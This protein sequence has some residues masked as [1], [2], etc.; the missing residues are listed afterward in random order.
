MTATDGTYM[1]I[2][3]SLAACLLVKIVLCLSCAY[4]LSVEI[5]EGGG[6]GALTYISSTGRHMCPCKD[7]HFV[8]CHAPKTSLFRV[9]SAHKT[10]LFRVGSAPK[11]ALFGLCRL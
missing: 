1:Y 10:P 2:I 7:P 4:I 6:G 3:I 8:T 11:T 9:G 5:R